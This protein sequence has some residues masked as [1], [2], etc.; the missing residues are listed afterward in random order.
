LERVEARQRQEADDEQQEV[1]THREQMPPEEFFRARQEELQEAANESLREVG[2]R[3][4]QPPV[5]EPARDTEDRRAEAGTENRTQ[6]EIKET[7]DAIRRILEESRD[8]L[9]EIKDES[10]SGA[11]FGP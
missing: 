2:R 7:L 10:G 3:Q 4:R 11:V 9:G 1:E 6:E 8:L 5:G